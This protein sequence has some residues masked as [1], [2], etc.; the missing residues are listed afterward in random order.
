MYLLLQ[1]AFE[2]G[3]KICKGRMSEKM[4][5]KKGMNCRIRE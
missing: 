1:V 2:N 3:V 4:Y 5:R